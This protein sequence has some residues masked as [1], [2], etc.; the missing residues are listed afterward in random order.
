M[1]RASEETWIQVFFRT[2][3]GVDAASCWRH[4]RVRRAHSTSFF[5]DEL[6]EIFPLCGLGCLMWDP[7]AAVT[8]T[9]WRLLRAM[10]ASQSTSHT[11]FRALSNST[12]HRASVSLQFNNL[13]VNQVMGGRVYRPWYA[14]HWYSHTLLIVWPAGIYGPRRG[15]GL[16]DCPSHYHT[17]R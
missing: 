7:L 5:L 14:P 17:A 12:Q 9:P 8:S 10:S 3:F 16:V 4:H 11:T 1:A 6:S 15:V 13:S 2:I